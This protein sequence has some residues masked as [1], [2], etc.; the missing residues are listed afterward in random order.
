MIMTRTLNSRTAS[1]KTA[2]IYPLWKSDFHPVEAPGDCGWERGF[3]FEKSTIADD[4]VANIGPGISVE[5]ITELQLVDLAVSG[6]GNGEGE[7]PRCLIKIGYRDFAD[8]EVFRGDGIGHRLGQGQG[9]PK[10]AAGEDQRHPHQR[11][12]GT[13]SHQ[14]RGR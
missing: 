6:I 10:A 11:G 13:P 9:G 1:P 7:S 4:W 8:E 3:E 5:G 12:H 14:A 2:G